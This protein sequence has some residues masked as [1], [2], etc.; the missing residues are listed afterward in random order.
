MRVGP[1]TL[2]EAKEFCSTRSPSM[3]LY[4]PHASET[5]HRLIHEKVAG[6]GVTTF[7]T[8]ASYTYNG[9]YD[10]FYKNRMRWM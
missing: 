3:S 1:S 2:T 7:W 8:R 4:K 9:D 10:N 6:L 5:I